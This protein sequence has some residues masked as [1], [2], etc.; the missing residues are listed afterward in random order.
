M[1]YCLTFS[2]LKVLTFFFLFS[3]SAISN[4]GVL[5]SLGFKQGYRVDV[6]V[7]EHS[8]VEAPLFHDII[9][10]NTGHW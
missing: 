10:F 1:S 4:G 3:W 7:P 9:I 6:D 5:E 8:W 2:L